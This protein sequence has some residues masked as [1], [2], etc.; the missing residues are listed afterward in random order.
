MLVNV[1]LVLDELVLHL[2]FQVGPLS[3]QSRHAI[4]HILHQVE[5]VQVVLNSHVEG[6]RDRSFLFV[7]PD[8]DVPIGS[9]V[10]QPVD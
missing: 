2:L 9:A 4:N 8:V 10:G 5:S 7:A 6:R 1:M 3:A